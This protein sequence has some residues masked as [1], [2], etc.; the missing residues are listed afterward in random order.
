MVLSRDSMATCILSMQVVTSDLTCDKSRLTSKLEHAGSEPRLV[1]LIEAS[2]SQG[3]KGSQS[4]Y[5]ASQIMT[6]YMQQQ[7]PHPSAPQ[8]WQGGWQ[9]PPSAGSARP[10]A[11][12][13]EPAGQQPGWRRQLLTGRQHQPDWQQS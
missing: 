11:W 6:Q 13:R 12:S 4:K 5:V 8:A 10:R 3:C 9:A 7:E 2:A 1:R